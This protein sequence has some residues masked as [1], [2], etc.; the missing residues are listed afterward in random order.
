MAGLRKL[1]KGRA[2]R[3]REMDCDELPS[4]ASNIDFPFW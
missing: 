2:R 1:A 3:P 4:N